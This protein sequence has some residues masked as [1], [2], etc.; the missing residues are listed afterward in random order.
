MNSD[1]LLLE[2]WRIASELHRHMD[3]II[4]R[5]FDYF[6]GLNVVLMG[7][8]GYVWQIETDAWLTIVASVLLPVLG[9]FISDK[10][11]RIH[12]HGQLYHI[13]RK[14]QAENREKALVERLELNCPTIGGR[15]DLLTVYGSTPEDLPDT[16]RNEI[17][18]GVFGETHTLDVVFKISRCLVLVWS[19]LLMLAMFV[20]ACRL[21]DLDIIPSVFSSPI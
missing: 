11:S 3:D 15:E 17:E 13:L 14:L 16:I 5:R 2:Q 21:L 20:L 18:H 10:W 6:V 19:L 7:A 9:I 4:W 12:A 1:D 8:L